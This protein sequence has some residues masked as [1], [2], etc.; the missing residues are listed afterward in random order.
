MKPKYIKNLDLGSKKVIYHKTIILE[1]VGAQSFVQDEEITL[2]NWGNVYV[3]SITKDPA[4]KLVTALELELH[5]SG[6]VKKTKKI[7]WLAASK[8][9]L[10]PVDLV[11][12]DH[13]I[14][15]DK[16]EEDDELESFLAKYT[17]FR[18]QAFADCNVGELSRR[19]VIQFERKG[20][21]KLDSMYKG[22]GSRMIFFDVP[23]GK[24]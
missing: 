8:T 24:S 6:D 18:T 11:A 7:S 10:I 3:R 15:K 9:N 1:Q 5:L 2:M 12:F 20:Y 21:Y 19:A 17:E 14:T 16:L 13:L 22:D 23:T 4:G